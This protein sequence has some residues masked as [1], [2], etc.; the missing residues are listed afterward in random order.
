MYI[1]TLDAFA[2][3]LD[4]PNAQKQ[5]AIDWVHV[6]GL[7]GRGWPFGRPNSYDKPLQK[8]AVEPHDCASRHQAPYLGEN[9]WTWRVKGME[10]IQTK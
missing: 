4:T 7:T 1:F 5:P 2:A 6:V 8:H 3:I 10:K 9:R